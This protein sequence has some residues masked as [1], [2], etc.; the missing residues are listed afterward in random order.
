MK[1]FLFLSALTL[2]NAQISCAA[3]SGQDTG[4]LNQKIG[5]LNADQRTKEAFSCPAP[6]GVCPM[7]Y[8]PARCWIGPEEKPEM[9]ASGP[10][11][12]MARSE[13]LGKW[14]LEAH[15]T[16]ASDL[17]HSK[18]DQGEEQQDQKPKTFEDGFVTCADDLPQA[19]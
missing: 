16:A 4:A 10:N 6:E 1:G 5:E 8:K 2:L 14:C 17:S 19:P 18:T 9:S 13:L 7:N 12:C 11:A 15:K 3:L